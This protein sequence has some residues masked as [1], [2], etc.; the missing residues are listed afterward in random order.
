MFF[1][2]SPSYPPM[3]DPDGP[4]YVAPKAQDGP[5]HVCTEEGVVLETRTLMD[6][7]RHHAARLS[8]LRG[9]RLVVWRDGV[10]KAVAEG[11]VCY[12]VNECMECESGRC[13]HCNET[14]FVRDDY[15]D[16]VR[17]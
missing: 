2:T 5:S 16:A 15:A 9:E 4:V 7:A 13:R 3:A 12:F 14:R 10:V 1:P 8:R 11:G 6:G 17:A